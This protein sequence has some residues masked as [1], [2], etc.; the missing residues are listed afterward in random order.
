MMQVGI[1]IADR[2]SA[3]VHVERDPDDALLVTAIE[4]LPFDLDVVAARVRELDAQDPE[5]RF[6]IDGGAGI[7]SALWAALAPPSGPRWQLYAG[8]GVERQQLVDGLLVAIHKGRFHFAAA[9]AEQEA[10]NKALQ[11]YRREVRDDGAIGSE[12]VVAVL[13]AIL[14]PVHPAHFMWA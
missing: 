7:G 2:A 4:R 3:I 10:M 6:V 1:V 9:L 5:A 14:P 11:G 12:L 13:L 8:R